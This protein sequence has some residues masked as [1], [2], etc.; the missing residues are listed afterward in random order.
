MPPMM[1]EKPPGSIAHIPRVC[2]LQIL[3]P[4]FKEMNLKQVFGK[5]ECVASVE[6]IPTAWPKVSRAADHNEKRLW[7]GD[8]WAS[9]P[10]P[11]GFLV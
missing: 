10:T 7:K 4:D 2:A 3:G 8:D 9:F 1:Y 11:C 6:T 5:A